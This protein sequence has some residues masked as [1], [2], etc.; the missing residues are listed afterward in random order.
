MEKELLWLLAGTFLDCQTKSLSFPSILLLLGKPKR[1]ENFHFLTSTLTWSPNSQPRNQLRALSADWQKCQPENVKVKIMEL[2]QQFLLSSPKVSTLASSLLFSGERERETKREKAGERKKGRK[3]KK[4][5]EVSS[6]IRRKD[7]FLGLLFVAFRVII[8]LRRWLVVLIGG[9]V[10]FVCH[11]LL[12]DVPCLHSLHRAIDFGS[13]PSLF[14]EKK[15]N[16]AQFPCTTA[17]AAAFPPKRKVVVVD[18]G[19]GC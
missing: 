7:L 14:K 17:S 12:T 15:S 16:S 1:K 5:T 6:W 10:R 4:R 2:P 8:W 13:S 3:K 11:W 18:I 19:V 9:R